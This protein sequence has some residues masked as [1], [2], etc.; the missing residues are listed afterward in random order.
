[1]YYKRP[2]NKM[3]T[4]KNLYKYGVDY[5]I[6][7]PSVCLIEFDQSHNIINLKSHCVNGKNKFF[8]NFLQNGINFE[9]KIT[10]TISKK[11]ALNDFQRFY[12][13]ADILVND[14]INQKLPNPKIVNIEGYAFA[15]KGKVFNIAENTQTFKMKMYDNF[16]TEFNI[17]EPSTLKK[18]AGQKGNC[19]KI[20]MGS[21]FVD[22]F[23]FCL[24]EKMDHIVGSSPVSDIIDSIFLALHK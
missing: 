1:M 5:S 11:D 3:S 22:N 18:F 17:I 7:S 15:A 16:K 13:I 6:T 12:A 9:I 23:G 14:I 20:A 21:A 10:P 19:D 2:K 24:Y 4:I 8:S